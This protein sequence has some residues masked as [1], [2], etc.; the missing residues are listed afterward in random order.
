MHKICG[1][2]DDW[3]TFEKNIIKHSVGYVKA[4]G[5][6]SL[7][8]G[9]SGGI[10]STVTCALARK[11]CNQLGIKLIG[12]SLPTAWNRVEEIKNADITGEAFC[13]EFYTYNIHNS[14]LKL[15][16]ELAEGKHTVVKDGEVDPVAYKKLK[17]R[18]GNIIARLRMTFLYNIAHENDGLV[19]STDNFTEYLLGFWTLHGDVGDFGM[20]QSLWKTEVYGLAYYMLVEEFAKDKRSW[21]AHALDVASGAVPTDGLGISAT[22]LDQIGAGSYEEVDKILVAYLNG[23]AV[24]LSHPVIKR[25]LRTHFKRNNPYNLRREDIIT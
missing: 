22:D 15:A 8:I 12:A 6:K 21:R 9:L 3:A 23:D 14:A 1:I 16:R 7:V 18:R 2:N 25:H 4:S 13:D 20:I 10:D 5:V 24:K 11:V 17:I 19:L